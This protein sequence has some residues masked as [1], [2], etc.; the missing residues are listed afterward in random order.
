MMKYV[1][2][3]WRINPTQSALDRESWIGSLIS[4]IEAEFP[5]SCSF[6]VLP[7]HREQVLTWLDTKAVGPHSIEELPDERIAVAVGKRQD[8]VRL[9]AIHRHCL[10]LGVIVASHSTEQIRNFIGKNK[11]R[12]AS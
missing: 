2:T 10:D 4:T 12:P 8:A 11:K 6:V 9:R 1:Q 5:I 3:L 7:D